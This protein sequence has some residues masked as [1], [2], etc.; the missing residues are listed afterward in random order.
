MNRGTLYIRGVPDSSNFQRA[1]SVQGRYSIFISHQG[2]D[3]RSATRLAESI[4]LLGIPCYVDRLDPNVDGDDPELESYLRG[5]IR[6]CRALLAVISRTH[7]T[8]M[9]GSTGNRCGLGKWQAHR[10]V[11]DK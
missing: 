2:Q 10:N 6:S 8:I 7:L 9:V 4:S 5:V 3:S 11:R 1:A